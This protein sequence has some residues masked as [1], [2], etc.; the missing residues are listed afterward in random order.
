MAGGPEEQRAAGLMRHSK[1]RCPPAGSNRGTRFPFRIKRVFPFFPAWPTESFFKLDVEIL[2]YKCGE[3]GKRG[4]SGKVPAWP[5]EAP[6][7]HSR[8][9]PGAAQARKASS[10]LPRDREAHS[11]LGASPGPA[12][13][14]AAL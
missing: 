3:V 2:N 13:L 14:G 8:P 12:L 11:S 5:E 6:G 4:N 10:H 9:R 1:S 7:S